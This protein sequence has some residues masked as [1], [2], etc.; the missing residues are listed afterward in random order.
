MSK[1]NIEKLQFQIRIKTKIQIYSPS[2]PNFSPL[3]EKS[4]AQN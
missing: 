1:F 3:L 4:L 2:T